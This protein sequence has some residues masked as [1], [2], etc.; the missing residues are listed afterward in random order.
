MA[1]GRAL[2]I[3]T[4]RFPPSN[5]T[6]LY[7]LALALTNSVLYLTNTQAYTSVVIIIDISPISV[8]LSNN[9]TK[10]FEPSC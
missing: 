1:V 8:S 3:H 6:C 10:L 5:C 9:L 7:L 2:V 4:T